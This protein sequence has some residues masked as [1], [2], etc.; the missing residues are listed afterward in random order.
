MALLLK[1][2]I[3]DDFSESE[4]RDLGNLIESDLFDRYV[5]QYKNENGILLRR[6]LYGIVARK[7]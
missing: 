4:N 2:P 7:R 6:V 3:L 5:K 1:T